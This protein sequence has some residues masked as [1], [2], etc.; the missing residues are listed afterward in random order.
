MMDSDHD[1]L[2]DMLR[3]NKERRRESWANVFFAACALGACAFL[4]FVIRWVANPY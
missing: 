4:A 2:R 3:T 1:T